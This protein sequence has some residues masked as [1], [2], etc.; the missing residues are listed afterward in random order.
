MGAA[1]VAGDR[2]SRQVARLLEG[3]KGSETGVDVNDTPRA[4]FQAGQV[5]RM[6]MHWPGTRQVGERGAEPCDS[7]G[8]GRL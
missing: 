2:P 3:P 8:R 4:I 6:L 5:C 1:R 7:M